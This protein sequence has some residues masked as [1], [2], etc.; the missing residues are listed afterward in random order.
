M[1]LT[2]LL[3][4]N[5][6]SFTIGTVRSKRSRWHKILLVCVSVLGLLINSPFTVYADDYDYIPIA[7]VEQYN[8]YRFWQ[9]YG[10]KLDYTNTISYNSTYS[11]TFTYSG[12]ATGSLVGQETASYNISLTGDIDTLG[13]GSGTGVL[14]TSTGHIY[15]FDSNAQ[16]ITLHLEP[17]DNAYEEN[18]TMA[19]H[20]VGAT[21]YPATDG[22]SYPLISTWACDTGGGY[23][24][25][26]YDLE[27]RTLSTGENGSLEVHL[28]TSNSGS[29]GI[30]GTLSFT[31]NESVNGSGTLSLNGTESTTGH[32]I[33]DIPM[34]NAE[35]FNN[36]SDPLKVFF[37]SKTNPFVI[38]T[39]SYSFIYYP[40]ALII[41]D[42]N[43]NQVT[44][45]TLKKIRYDRIGGYILNCY[46]ITRDTDFNATSIKLGSFPSNN[47]I[48]PL[49]V[50]FKNDMSDKLYRYLYSSDRTDE[51]IENGNSQTSQIVSNVE[52]SNYQLTHESDALHIFEQDQ[53]NNMS[54]ALND[55]DVGNADINTNGFVASANWIVQQFNWIVDPEPIRKVLVFTLTVGIALT[56]LGKLR[57]R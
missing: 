44:D 45:Y 1:M 33:Y 21:Q 42:G 16:P 7:D 2:H 47:S 35:Q 23:E 4:I 20:A 18:S 27:L 53:S 26:T 55:I 56:I 24:P 57:N 41:C 12:A 52:G 3:K 37:P 48:L 6:I 31:S 29:G 30:T 25:T 13:T 15:N 14:Y 10:Y 36:N 39:L 28:N 38:A 17:Q 32:K 34:L 49:Y 8:A 19:C 5:S 46:E 51:L 11:G 54:A 43:F 22:R 50:G 40:D 9:L